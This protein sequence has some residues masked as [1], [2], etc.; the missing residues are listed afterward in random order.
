MGGVPLASVKNAL[1]ICSKMEV[2]CEPKSGARFCLALARSQ[3]R[4]VTGSK[5]G[6][7]KKGSDRHRIQQ[8]ATCLSAFKMGHPNRVAE[9]QTSGNHT[10]QEATSTLEEN[11]AT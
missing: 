10:K 6:F 7:Q 9:F 8:E 11:C 3:I 1:P 4:K 5:Q 2:C